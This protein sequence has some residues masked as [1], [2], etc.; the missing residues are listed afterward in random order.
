MDHDYLSRLSKSPS[1][2]LFPYS[3]QAYSTKDYLYTLVVQDTSA[4]HLKEGIK[5]ALSFVDFE[6]VII[7]IATELFANS[8]ECRMLM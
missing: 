4:V 2:T 6:G 3:H 8:Q 1:S 5:R 7:V